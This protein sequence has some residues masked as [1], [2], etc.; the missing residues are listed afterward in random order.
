MWYVIF[1]SH[2]KKVTYMGERLNITIMHNINSNC[3][4]SLAKIHRWSLLFGINNV[5]GQIHRKI[6]F[7]FVCVWR[8]CE[9]EGFNLMWYSWSL[10]GIPKSFTSLY[11]HQNQ[12][13]ILLNLNPQFPNQTQKFPYPLFICL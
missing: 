10:V 2:E 6:F 8:S 7:F 12:T 5:Y 13:K 1:L 3:W 4:P 11:K 9:E